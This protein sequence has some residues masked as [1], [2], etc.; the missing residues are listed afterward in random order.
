MSDAKHTK[1]PWRLG[2]GGLPSK[3]NIWAAAAWQVA[4][5]CRFTA[6]D[7]DRETREDDTERVPDGFG[8]VQ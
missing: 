5:V 8:G 6:A 7:V 3:L 4:K 2:E 1:G